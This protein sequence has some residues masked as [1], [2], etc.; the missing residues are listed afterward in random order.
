MP[1][2]MEPIFKHNRQIDI[3]IIND[4]RP[5]TDY[6][7]IQMLF[8]AANSILYDGC[9]M[10]ERMH[11]CSMGEEPDSNDG[12]IQCWEK[13]L[14]YLVNRGTQDPFRWDKAIED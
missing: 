5:Y 4:P 6:E 13:Y 2:R 8:R 7:R 14:L 12:C 1:I 10:D 9:P 3:K 11:M